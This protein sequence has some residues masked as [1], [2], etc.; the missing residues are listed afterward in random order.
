MTVL[1]TGGC[2][3]V[4]INLAEALLEAGEAVV[5]L[6]RIALPAVAHD[7]LTKHSSRFSAVIA[8]VQDAASMSA[9]MAD[10]HV[11][12]VVHAAVVTSDVAREAREP[13][14]IVGVNVGGTIKV[15]EAARTANCR[16]FIYVGSGQAYGAT[17]DA[18]ELLDERTSPSRPNDIYGISKFCAEAIAL[19]LG[20]LW[21]LEVACVRLGSVCGPW[22]FDTGVR[23][24][25]SPYLC[26]AQLAVRGAEA[27]V[28][29]KEPWRDWVYS[30][31]VAE[32]L[33]ALL[34][35]SALPNDVYH[36]S[37]GQSWHD[38]FDHWCELLRGSYPLF[39]WRRGRVDE[40]PNVSFVV[41]RDRSPMNVARIASDTGFAA[42]FGPQEAYVDYLSWIRAHEDFIRGNG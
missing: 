6:D 16:R 21:G 27:V 7:A 19:R 38:S 17:H 39:S 24:M 34:N 3:F 22:E 31:D 32:G 37:S 41:E 11:R 40:Q 28:P 25:L 12:C 18:G 30:R 15:L 2:G 10:H 42:R 29:R 4:G 23:D 13:G 14:S 26:T 36:L 9:V 33:R 1:I 20:R 35:A 8:D 5:L